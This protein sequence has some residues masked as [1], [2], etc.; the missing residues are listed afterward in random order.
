MIFE[1]IM[2]GRIFDI[3]RFSVHDGPGIRT[4]VF[5]KGCPLKCPWCHN[6][7]GLSYAV[8]PQFFKDECIGCGSCGGEHSIEKS[9][10]CPTGALRAAG[11]DISAEGLLC[12]LL[13]DR[14][15]YGASGGVTFSGGECLMQSEFVTDVLKLVKEEGI[16]TAVDTSGA[17]EWSRIEATL[18]HTDIYLYDIKCASPDTHEKFTGLDNRLILENLERLDKCGKRIFIRTPVIPSFNDNIEEMKKIAHILSRLT[19]VE[20]LTLIPYHT[21]GKNK[22][23]TL[24]EKP[25]FSTD[26]RISNEKLEEYKEIFIEN[27]IFTD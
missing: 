2:I 25:P 3:Q 23:E 15:F 18:P 5:M 9:R 13:L 26:E 14:D 4:T 11:R 1:V 24:G 22:Y 8:Q 19:N 16:S 21:L 17:V 7:E 27:G 6:P 12:E 20:R 10:I